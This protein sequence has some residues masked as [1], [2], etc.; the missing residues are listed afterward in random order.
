[1]AITASLENRVIGR[2]YLRL[3]NSRRFRIYE[4]ELLIIAKVLAF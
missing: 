1:M 3:P 2:T 4:Q